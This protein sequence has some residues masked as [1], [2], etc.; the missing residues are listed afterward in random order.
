MSEFKC[1][2]PLLVLLLRRLMSVQCV[3]VSQCCYWQWLISA[4]RCTSSPEQSSASL[5]QNCTTW[6]LH[7]SCRYSQKKQQQ[8]NRFLQTVVVNANALFRVFAEVSQN[9]WKDHPTLIWRCEAAR[10][11]AVRSIPAGRHAPNTTADLGPVTPFSTSPPPETP[12]GKV[13]T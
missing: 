11:D 4:G 13:E 3:S 1:K 8:K 10:R 7:C 12:N 5:R 6:V 9:L 2:A